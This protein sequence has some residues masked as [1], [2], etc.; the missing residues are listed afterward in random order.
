MNASDNENA[1]FVK[2]GTR[3]CQ[4]SNKFGTNKISLKSTTFYRLSV[5]NSRPKFADVGSFQ[6]KQK[7][8]LTGKVLMGFKTKYKKLFILKEKGMG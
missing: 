7:G 4:E 1:F 6:V 5:S 3:R 2:S 8:N